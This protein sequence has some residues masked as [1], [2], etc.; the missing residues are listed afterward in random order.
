MQA[1]GYDLKKHLTSVHYEGDHLVIT[2][3][4]HTLLPVNPDD[5]AILLFE[6]PLP[7]RNVYDG[8]V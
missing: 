3:F 7:P 8:V 1:T 4:R 2:T 5:D 6:R